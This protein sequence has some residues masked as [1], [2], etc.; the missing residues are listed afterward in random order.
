MNTD[1][2]FFGLTEFLGFYLVGF[3][4]FTWNLGL[5]LFGFF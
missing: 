4:W 5:V 1:N 2:P 3:V